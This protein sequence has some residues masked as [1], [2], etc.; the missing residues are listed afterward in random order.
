MIPFF[1][2]K[3][4]SKSLHPFRGKRFVSVVI[5][6]SGGVDSAV[7]AYLLKQQVWVVFLHNV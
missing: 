1:G 3:L 6:C 4:L 7:S 2:R 5:G